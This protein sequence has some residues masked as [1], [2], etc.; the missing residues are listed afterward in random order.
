MTTEKNKEGISLEADAG[1]ELNIGSSNFQVQ[2]RKVQAL[3]RLEDGSLE[4][5]NLR[6]P[7]QNQ[8]PR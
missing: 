2:A 6:D 1:F 3:F 5:T 7:N 8:T 4:V